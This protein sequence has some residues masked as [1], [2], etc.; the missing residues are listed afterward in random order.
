MSIL[1]GCHSL[2]PAHAAGGGPDA[3]GVESD[4]AHPP[5]PCYAVSRLPALSGILVLFATFNFFNKSF[6]SKG[7]AVTYANST[8]ASYFWSIAATA[9][10]DR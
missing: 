8:L 1:I 6:F 9:A 5:S 10:Y 2:S 7:F 3:G 4:V